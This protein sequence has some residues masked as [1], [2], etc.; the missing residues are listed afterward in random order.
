MD[1]SRDR[2]SSCQI[3][4]GSSMGLNAIAPAWA[5]GP[6]S[7]E[8]RRGDKSIGMEGPH[9]SEEEEK[10]ERG[11]HRNAKQCQIVNNATIENRYQR[12][13]KGDKAGVGVS[14]LRKQ[15][16]QP[17]RGGVAVLLGKPP[18]T[19]GLWLQRQST[20]MGETA[21]SC[22]RQRGL[23]SMWHSTAAGGKE[24]PKNRLYSSEVQGLLFW[25]RVTRATRR[26]AIAVKESMSTP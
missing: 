12:E 25:E 13:H 20:G 3:D 22:T 21:T 2:G 7:R 5:P 1:K 24:S 16:M 10:W 17:G 8:D 15:H 11:K 14:L 9:T 4:I 26:G 18:T 23:A 6:S 19:P